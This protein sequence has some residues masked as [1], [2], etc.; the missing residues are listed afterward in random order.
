MGK[1]SLCR[2]PSDE[3]EHLSLYVIGTEGIW[4][5]LPCRIVL[6]KLAGAIRS[7]SNRAHKVGWLSGKG[8]TK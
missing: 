2:D 3:L 4:V 1:C 6:T 8:E 7:A 5:C